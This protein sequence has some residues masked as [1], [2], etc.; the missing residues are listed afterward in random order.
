MS[1]LWSPPLLFFTAER[2]RRGQYRRERVGI[3]NQRRVKV[4]WQW[5]GRGGF[6]PKRPLFINDLGAR[7]DWRRWGDLEGKEEEGW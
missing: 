3:R 4:Q 2:V 7:R 5:W 6:D 1:G